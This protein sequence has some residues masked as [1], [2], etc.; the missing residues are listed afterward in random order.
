MITK[1]DGVKERYEDD[2]DEDMES[3]YSITSSA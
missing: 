1:G 2:T 3:T